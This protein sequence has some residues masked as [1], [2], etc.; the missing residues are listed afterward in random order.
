M[1]VR[2][3][4]VLRLLIHVKMKEKLALVFYLLVLQFILSI[5]VESIFDIYGIGPGDELLWATLTLGFLE[6]N[7]VHQLEI[8]FDIGRGWS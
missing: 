5:Y 8:S 3:F 4:R 6:H 1:Y 7:F 2:S